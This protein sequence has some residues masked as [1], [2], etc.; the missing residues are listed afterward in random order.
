VA[1]RIIILNGAP[2]SGKSSI[3]AA[4]QQHS[5]DI[6]I[7]LGVDV[8]I[9]MTPERFRPGIGL[10]PGGER[11]DL[12]PTVETLYAAL[13]DSIAAHS[14]LGLD[15]VSDLGVHDSYSRPLAIWDGLQRR[16]AGLPLLTVGV[17]CPI[18][19]IMARRLA[20]PQGGHYL[21][22]PGVPEPVARWQA[23]V[24]EGKVY[25]LTVDT[26]RLTPTACAAAIVAM[27]TAAGP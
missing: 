6:C 14:R 23:A 11:P 16:L 25:D 12:E 15:V 19:T 22:G 7:D 13:F 17:L 3:A 9:A 24:H 26:A 20:D 21:S 4:L 10:R 18:E 27:L 8:A 5:A 2:R 1:G